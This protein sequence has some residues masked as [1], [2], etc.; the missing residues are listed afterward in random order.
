MSS[1]EDMDRAPETSQYNEA[2]AWHRGDNPELEDHYRH[3]AEVAVPVVSMGMEGPYAMVSDDGV[4]RAY[5]V[6]FVVK[7]VLE[8][9]AT[10]EEVE[11]ELVVRP[12]AMAEDML[13][14]FCAAFTKA[15][16]DAEKI[17][18]GELIPE[19]VGVWRDPQGA[20]VDPKVSRLF[21]DMP[22]EGREDSDTRMMDDGEDDGEDDDE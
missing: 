6:H 5:V 7:A 4:G 10:G 15:V 13:L 18:Q 21:R 1:S 8:D 16:E 22:N 2:I 12:M 17:R 11:R 20:V 3:L 9:R 14:R 19:E